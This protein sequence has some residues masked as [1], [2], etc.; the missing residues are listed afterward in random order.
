M[1][2]VVTLAAA[3]ALPDETPHVATCCGW[4]RFVVVGGTLL[5][6]GP[7]LPLAGPPAR[8]ARPGPG[9]GRPRR[10]PV[11][12]QGATRAGLAR[13][14]EIQR[15]GRRAPVVDRPAARSAR[16]SSAPTRPGSGSARPERRVGDAERDL[17]PAAAGDAARRARERAARRA[18][19]A[20]C[21][22]RG[23][24]RGAGACSTSRSRMLDRIGERRR[25]PRERVED[26][27]G[28]ALVGQLRAPARGADGRR[29]AARRTAA[30]SACGTALDLG[31]PAA[32]PDLRARRLLRL[33]DRRGTPSC[34]STRPSTR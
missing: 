7:T 20:S 14:D 9:G 23:A 5:I 3:F 8:P 1:R 25:R 11:A 6:Q 24:P 16:A 31:A 17:P 27:T 2:G 22:R 34:T 4:S 26:L 33:L 12:L 18:T 32:V 21:R 19:P 30:R 29:T 28:H 10:R 15:R 13:L